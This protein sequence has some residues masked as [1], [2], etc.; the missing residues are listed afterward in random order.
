MSKY[1]PETNTRVIYLTCIEC[2][3]KSCRS[4]APASEPKAERHDVKTKKE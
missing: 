4:T 1:C 3:T 2:E